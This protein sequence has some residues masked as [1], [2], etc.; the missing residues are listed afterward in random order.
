M[1][2]SGRARTRRPTRDSAVTRIRPSR[3]SH[4]NR[5][6][7]ARRCGSTGALVAIDRSTWRVAASSPAIWN[8]ELP[9]PTTSTGPGGK[10]RGLRYPALCS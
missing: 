4:Q 8:P 5:S 6:L 9:P 1:T 7:P 2:K 3:V 10:A